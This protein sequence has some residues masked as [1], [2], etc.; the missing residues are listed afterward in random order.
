VIEAAGPVHLPARGR[1]VERSAEQVGDAVALVHH[2]EHGVAAEAADVVRLP[3]GGGV[4]R[5]A[6]EVDPAAA[7]GPVHHR[8]L[9]LAEVGVAVIEAVGHGERMGARGATRKGGKELSP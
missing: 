4:E 2:V 8:G 7:V 3:P 6:V 5:G 1:G 9:E